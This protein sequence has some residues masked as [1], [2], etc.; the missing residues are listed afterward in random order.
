MSTTENSGSFLGLRGENCNFTKISGVR[1]LLT[2]DG[3]DLVRMI[4]NNS[5]G[6]DNTELMATLSNVL[7]RIDV[8]ENY[9]QNSIH[10]GPPG[11]P[12]PPG[13]Q[14]LQGPKGP[15]GPQGPQGPL[16]LKLSDLIDVDLNGLDEGAVLE[17]ST[18]QNKWVVAL[19]E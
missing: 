3:Y 2:H 18:Q 10:Q 5:G 15:Q 16:K 14:G 12:G 17:W 1:E 8:I 6:G 11:P 7:A 13:P 19:T 4:K 9:L